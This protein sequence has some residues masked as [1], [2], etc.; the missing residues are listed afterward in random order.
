MRSQ[1]A[2]RL[3]ARRRPRRPLLV[4]LP[5]PPPQRFL[6]FPKQFPE[7]AE[8]RHTGTPSYPKPQRGVL[9][10]LCRCVS[11]GFTTPET[12]CLLAAVQKGPRRCS[13]STWR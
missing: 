3:R 5:A 6:R 2:S 7:H 10:V 8:C 13:I 4:Q 9:C 1:P 11:D 12:G